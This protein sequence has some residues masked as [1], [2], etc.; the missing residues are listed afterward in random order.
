MSSGGNASSLPLVGGLPEPT[1]KEL[2][3]PGRRAFS[4]PKLD[5][6]EENIEHEA[7]KTEKEVDIVIDKM[8]EEGYL[9]GIKYSKDKLL[10]AVTEKR[11]KDEI[12]RYVNTIKKVLNE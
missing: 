10:I 2:S 4:Y 3:K 6:P 9:A 5:V 1:I 7:I 11:T 12:D 8:A